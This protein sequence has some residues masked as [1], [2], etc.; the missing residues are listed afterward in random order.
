MMYM[1]Q[2]V[3]VSSNQ[4]VFDNSLENNVQHNLKSLNLKINVC[5][6]VNAHTWLNMVSFNPCA[7]VE[8][9]LT[10]IFRE[11]KVHLLKSIKP[12]AIILLYLK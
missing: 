7:A 10:Y 5:I 9:I 1:Q 8:Y 12:Q 6:Y 3:L 4:Y 2:F 11:S